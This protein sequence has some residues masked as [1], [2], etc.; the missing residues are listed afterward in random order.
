VRTLFIAVV[1]SA[2]PLT[3]W[4]DPAASTHVTVTGQGVGIS[5]MNGGTIQTGLTQE[6]VAAL[7]KATGEELVRD[8]TRI[9]ERTLAKQ[10]WVYRQ[11]VSIGVV[12]A[13]LANVKGRNIPQSEWPQ[14]FAELT[15]QCLPS[16]GP[17]RDSATTASTEVR[18]AENKHIGGRNRVLPDVREKLFIPAQDVDNALTELAFWARW[19]I[20][21]NPGDIEHERS[22]PLDRSLEPRAAIA[23]L[24]VGTGLDYKFVGH[25]TVFVFPKRSKSH[26]A[27]KEDVPVHD[28]DAVPTS[29]DESNVIFG[30]DEPRQ[31]AGNIAKRGFSPS[32]DAFDNLPEFTG[33]FCEQ[34]TG[35]PSQVTR[36][37][38]ARYCGVNFR[39][40]G[41]P[42]PA[43]LLDGQRV[44][45]GDRNALFL[46]VLRLPFNIIVPA[47]SSTS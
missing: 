19:D 31:L 24:L 40:M 18:E 20:I 21:L 2:V 44:P 1:L 35:D 23:A 5:Q 29:S 15:T 39:S 17:E 7:T 22:F 46:D 27:P 42:T 3:A 16:R 45:P 28:A 4:A 47:V 25:H 33:D 32:Q 13:F 41:A 8:L 43:V 36:T 30:P 34:G 9:L 37:N 38:S 12:E 14:A 6:D 26:S 10:G 11:S